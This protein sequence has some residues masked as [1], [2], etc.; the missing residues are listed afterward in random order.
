MMLKIVGGTDHA[1]T[2]MRRIEAEIDAKL[3]QQGGMPNGS[4]KNN[5][6]RSCVASQVE[7]VSATLK[8]KRLRDKR[9]AM[10]ERAAA[11]T[12][13][14]RAR[15]EMHDAIWLA[16]DRGAA[17]GDLHPH[18]TPELSRALTLEL[19]AKYREAIAKQLLTPAPHF[20]S[21]KWKETASRDLYLPIKKEKSREPSPP[22]WRSL[23]HIQYGAIAG[24]S[25]HDTEIRRPSP[26][27]LVCARHYAI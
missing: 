12:Q 4:A 15:R 23:P 25:I 3:L 27:G 24:A 5:R 2:I 20:G 17:E 7:P 10:W 18:D 11:A 13:Y 14:W 9:N 1:L 21:V 16:Q 6:P 22:I 26:G 19:L 8:N